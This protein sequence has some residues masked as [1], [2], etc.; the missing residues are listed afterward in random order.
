M[1]TT[2]LSCGLWFLLGTQTLVAAEVAKPA[3]TDPSKTQEF[4]KATPELLDMGKVVFAVHCVRCHGPEGR[5]DGV[6]ETK[7]PVAPTNFRKVRMKYGDA[8]ESVV[9][10]V[11]KGRSEL[12][13]PSFQGALSTKEIWAAAHFV[14]SL[15]PAKY[16]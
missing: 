2:L 7:L 3:A 9:Q 6:E 4:L 8:L 14:K 10:T 15:M 5:G 16:D 12:V 11:A 1:M 13:M